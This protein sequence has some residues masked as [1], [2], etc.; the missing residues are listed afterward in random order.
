MRHHQ[1]LM[2]AIWHQCV[3]MNYLHCCRPFVKFIAPLSVSLS[4]AMSSFIWSIQH[5]LCLPLFLFPS[6]LA[7]SALCGI[8]TTVFL[9]VQDI[10]VFI[11]QLC[12]ASNL[13]TGLMLV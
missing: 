12:L 10:R 6:N 5:S 9:H 13:I 11:E 4:D 8:R 3:R 1:F 7:C 2:S